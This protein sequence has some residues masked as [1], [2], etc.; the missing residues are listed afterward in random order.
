MKKEHTRRVDGKVYLFGTVVEFSSK[1]GTRNCYN[2]QWDA[3]FLGTT[4]VEVPAILHGIKIRRDL[5]K[6][7]SLPKPP[8]RQD[9]PPKIF[10]T[11]ILEA[12]SRVE[13]GEEGEPPDSESDQSEGEEDTEHYYLATPRRKKNS[14]CCKANRGQ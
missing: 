7:V 11:K 14:I 1:K 3:H 8:P 12:L 2:V 6:P 10:S 9:L 5:N 4:P 13:K